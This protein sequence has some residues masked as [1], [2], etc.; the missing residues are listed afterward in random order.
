[1]NCPLCAKP[2]VKQSMQDAFGNQ[3][4]IYCEELVK[5]PGDP[6]SFNHYREDPDINTVTMYVPPFRIINENG[7]TK[8]GKHAQYKKGRRLRT[9]SNT[10]KFYYKTIIKCPTIHPDTEEKLRSR[11]KL[12]LVMS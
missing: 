6:R 12:L 1:M 3:P 4:A 5:V 2:L 9:R 8:I 7:E 11:I 10:K